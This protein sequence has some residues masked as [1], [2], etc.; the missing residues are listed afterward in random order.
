MALAQAHQILDWGNDSSHPQA[1]VDQKS[2]SQIGLRNNEKF[3]SKMI[4]EL[5]WRIKTR[6]LA[7]MTRSTSS[8]KGWLIKLVKNSG[9]V[10][11]Q[12]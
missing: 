9:A 8:W 7:L 10:N 6:T 5:L 11:R 3:L 12:M 2:L 1:V 4:L